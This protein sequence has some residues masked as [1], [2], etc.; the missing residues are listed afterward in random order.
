MRAGIDG[1]EIMGDDLPSLYGSEEMNRID[2]MRGPLEYSPGVLGDKNVVFF[3][4][5]GRLPGSITSHSFSSSS[6][7]V[8]TSSP[9]R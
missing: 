5:V 4:R 7:T 1:P 6:M 3:L 9:K 2:K 8:S